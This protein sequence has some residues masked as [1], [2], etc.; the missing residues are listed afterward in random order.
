MENPEIK[1]NLKINGGKENE[2]RTIPSL[3]CKA[4]DAAKVVLKGKYMTIQAFLKK[5][6][7]F[8]NR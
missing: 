5:Q 7:I 6:V 3:G 2:S 4:W 8:C 1:Q